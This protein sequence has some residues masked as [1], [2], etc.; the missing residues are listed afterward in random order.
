MSRMTVL[1][2][3]PM[4]AVWFAMEVIHSSGRVLLDIVTPGSMTTPRV[5]CLDARSRT[6]AELTLIAALITLT[7]GTLT[8]G[9]RGI[10]DRRVLLVHSMYHAN[11]DEALED[12][13]DMED[14]MLRALAVGERP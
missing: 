14:R 7:P 13:H 6:D 8:L 10:G 12:L 9:T 2:R 4:F 3:L 11:T 5:V 1:W